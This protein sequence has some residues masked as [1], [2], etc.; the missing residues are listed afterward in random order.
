[1]RVSARLTVFTAAGVF[2]L[3][4]I[5]TAQIQP[6]GGL[7]PLE[8]A[9]LAANAEMTRAAE[10]VDADRLFSFMLDTDK[11]SVIQNGVFLLTRDEALQRVKANLGRISK[12]EYRWKRQYV[13]VLSPEAALLTAEGESTATTADGRTFTTPFAQTVVFVMRE[14][15]WK[16]IHAHQSS[17]R[18]EAGLSVPQGENQ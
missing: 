8:E 2:L 5:V 1:M 7:G 12:I 18:A 16:V 4:G 11:G 14:G 13:T 6:G 17:P 10:A 3:A 9:V 15:R